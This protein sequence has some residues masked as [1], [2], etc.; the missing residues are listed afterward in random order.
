[1]TMRTADKAFLI[2]AFIVFLSL[3]A[4][5]QTYAF[6]QSDAD[7]D[8]DGDKL[9][10]RDEFFAGTNPDVYTA[11][12][13]MTEK[14]LLDLFAGKAFLYF[15]EQSRLSFYF[16]PD[17]ANYNDSLDY[18]ANFNSI[19]TTGFSLMAYVVADDRGWVDHDA[20]YERIRAL[21]SRAVTLQSSAYDR[22]GVPA[23]QEGNRHGYLYH[24][25]D[26]QGFRCPGSEISTIDHALFVAGA[27]AAGEY[28]KGTEVEQLARQ[29]YLNTDWNWLYNGTFLYQ[30]WAEDSAGGF[31][32]GRTLDSWNRYS[33][34]MILLFL[35]MGSGD[36][37]MAIPPSAWD[38]LTYGTGRMFPFEYAHL[39]P[40]DAPQ[41]FAFVS[42]MPNTIHESGYT[43]S[44]SEFHYIHAGSLHNHQYSHLF[45]NFRARRDRW[46]TDYFANSISAAMANRQYCVN[47]STHA[48]GGDPSSPDQYTRQPYETYGPNSWGIM[49][50][51]P[52]FTGYAV[53]QPI[54]MS[55]DNFSPDNIA[56]NND[57]GTVVLS[58]PLGSTPFTP[59]QTIDFT[60]NMLM[61]FQANEWGYDALVGRYGFMN[62]F[63]LGRPYNSLQVGH[64]AVN[65]IGLDMGPVIGSVEN[66]TGGLV[67][68]MAMRNQFIQTG[69]QN[70]GFNTGV[71]EPFILNFDDNSPLP[72]EDPN[73]GGLDPN[74]FGGSSYQFGTGAIS[75][76]WIGDP[77]PGLPYGP[78]Q[79]A[80][81][82]SASDNTDSGAF[83][84]LS[85]HDVSRWDT[86]S[87]W[88]K[89]DIGTEEYSVGLK[90][91]VVD[92]L[93]NPLEAIEVKIPIAEYHSEGAITS[94]WTGVR[95]PL[96]DFA[97]KGVRLTALDN[98]S[99]TNTKEGGGAIYVDDIA[100]L[101]D[102]FKPSS[103]QGLQETISG[104]SIELSW[105]AN[106][107]PDL[108]GYRVYRSDDQGATFNPL[109]TNL[110]VPTV[111]TDANHPY[112]REL[113]R[114]TAVDNAQPANESDPSET[115]SVV[116]NQPPLAGTII[117]SSGSSR[118]NKSVNFTTTYSDGDGWQNIQSANLLINTSTSG[119][120]CFYGYYDQNTNKL[121]I[122][123]DTNTAWLGGYAPGSHKA[124][125]N[126]Y[127]K[128]N[129]A[130]TT[131]SGSG[132]T[133][134][135]KWNIIFKSTFAG[136]K[137]MYLYVKDDR[138]AYDGWVLKGTWT[139][140]R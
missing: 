97:E 87:F 108:V 102:E 61:R 42:N 62:S 136:L 98:I 138:G 109:N 134:T 54:V 119:S 90:G 118:V 88:I 84:T 29:L 70:A 19:A 73:G 2:L 36:A 75:Y 63:N 35:A 113:Y 41:N 34:L 82:I 23:N 44:A 53:L 126:S 55:Y 139:I 85:S 22:V 89:G 5:A 20:A 105:D 30:G 92:R 13:S 18:S 106:T 71:V 137:N 11:V 103:P 131:V 74:S 91:G 43:N 57:S 77:F 39:F 93:G 116:I 107:E 104:N 58:A 56:V 40:G 124:I 38:N 9:T 120:K 76:A 17:K 6:A 95:I 132:N 31:E 21:L 60:R 46:Q 125:N 96:R 129:C 122:R 130:S 45:A 32:G 10:N 67:W 16:T 100:F 52:S 94:Q 28:Y 133:L 115:I 3:S 59:R 50:G 123:N 121:Y 33:E 83:I 99:F 48:F 65:I 110:V 8:P 4:L 25:V 79:W 66:Y 72:Q 26:D 12:N 69:M 51:I 114:I 111:Y 101:G 78:Q 14:Q 128:L 49:A 68:K 7:L 24:F 135:I 27:L 81:Q 37:S 112:S 47:L 64:F 140:R 1:M 127:V 86:L 117:P 80:Q 15:W